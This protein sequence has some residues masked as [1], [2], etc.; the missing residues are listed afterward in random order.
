MDWKRICETTA[1]I[2]AFEDGGAFVRS[3]ADS[4]ASIRRFHHLMMYS[5]SPRH[6]FM[7]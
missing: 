1:D 6:S 3:C 7:P 5:V 2:K 4:Q